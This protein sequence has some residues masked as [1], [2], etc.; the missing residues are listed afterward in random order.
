M[1]SIVIYATGS[2]I[3]ADVE[4]SLARARVTILA[5]VR[6]RVGPSYLTGAA[7]EI[8]PNLLTA[9]LLALPYLVPLFTPAHRHEAA[10]EALGHGFGA[11]FSLIDTSVS[12]PRAIAFEQGLYIGAG[13]TLG[14]ASRFGSFAFI[15][16][17]ASIG[18]HCHADAFVSVGPGA[19]IAGEVKIGKGVVIGAGAVV[20]PQITI[21]HNAVVG[22][23]AV[24][25]HDVPAH[26]VV[27]G[28]PAR[29]IKT[30]VAGYGGKAV[31]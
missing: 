29:V 7:R 14:A 18:H 31:L 6:N 21:G 16:R 25:T 28:N 8:E 3:L 2:P 30:G 9:E 1:Q 26:T 19:V 11:A 24:V 22:A 27:F 20:L 17:G 15:N 10:T 5:G 13:V 4:E 23:G 12:V